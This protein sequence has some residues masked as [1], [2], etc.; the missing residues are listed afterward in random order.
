MVA[1]AAGGRAREA[2]RGAA[3][4]ATG[5][6]ADGAGARALRGAAGDR[7]VEAG[8]RGAA[9]QGRRRGWHVSGAERHQW[10][11]A[12]TLGFAQEAAAREDFKGALQWLEVVEVVDGVLPVKWLRTRASWPRWES[13]AACAGE[14][15]VAHAT[16]EP[17]VQRGGL[18]RTI[19]C[20]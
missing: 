9:L 16:V 12:Q 2:C 17:E 18:R 4:I 19:E 8:E 10:A 11:V 20:Q 14:A 3:A 5:C 15:P 6:G 13:A 7:G 1:G